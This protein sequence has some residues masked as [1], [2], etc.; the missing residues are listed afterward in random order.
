MIIYEIF[1]YQ[2]RLEAVRSAFYSVN[3]ILSKGLLFLL[4][5]LASAGC[6]GLAPL[7]Q[8]K[9]V[10]LEADPQATLRWIEKD[11]GDFVKKVRE[12]SISSMFAEMQ[13]GMRPR[14]SYIVPQ[15]LIFEIINYCKRNR[16]D[17]L[18]RLS[19]KLMK[20]LKF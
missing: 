13:E 12:D 19:K 11:L 10:A 1:K 8:G 16:S 2:N 17:P 9:T 14:Q 5:I 15:K 20:Y 6:Y 3:P 4:V 18:F 7:S